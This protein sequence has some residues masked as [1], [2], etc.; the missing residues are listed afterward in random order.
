MHRGGGGIQ[1]KLVGAVEV[2]MMLNEGRQSRLH[3]RE[4]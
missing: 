4:R 2:V 1:S 3:K